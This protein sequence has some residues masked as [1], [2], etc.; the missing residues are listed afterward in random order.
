MADRILT[1]WNYVSILRKAEIHGRLILIFT[2]RGIR[3]W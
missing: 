3:K 2:F 1:Y